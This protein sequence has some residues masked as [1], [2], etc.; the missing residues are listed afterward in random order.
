MK[1]KIIEFLKDKFNIALIVLQVLAIICYFLNAYLFFLLL[2]F[3]LESAFLI[4][5]GI[6]YFVVNGDSKYKMAIYDQLP[7]TTA[8]KQE[9]MKNKEKDS[10]NNKIMGVMLILLGVA[11]LFTGFSII[12]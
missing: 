4:V 12:F 10:K 8:Q 7:Y 5:W 3:A 9:I 2:F 1:Q 11:M 6:K